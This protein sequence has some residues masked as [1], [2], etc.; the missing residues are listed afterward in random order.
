MRLNTNIKCNF[1]LISCVINVNTFIKSILVQSDK[2]QEEKKCSWVLFITI[3]CIDMINEY[4]VV[5][6]HWFTVLKSKVLYFTTYNYLLLIIVIVFSI[7][8]YV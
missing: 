2:K 3:K 5:D 1:F 7:V 8:G 4:D 6:L